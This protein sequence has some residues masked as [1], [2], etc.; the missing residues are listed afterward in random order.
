MILATEIA[1]KNRDFQIIDDINA[2]NQADLIKSI[3]D[4]NDGL[5]TNEDI[6][7]T[8]YNRND[9]NEPVA[10]QLHPNVLKVIKA[11]IFQTK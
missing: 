3:L 4:P 7:Q 1:K 10:P 8:D 5:I 6:D 11:D 2:K 9:N